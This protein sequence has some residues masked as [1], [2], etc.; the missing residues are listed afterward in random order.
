MGGNV[1]GLRIQICRYKIG[2]VKNSIGNGVTKELVC[3][4]HRLN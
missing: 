1:Q 2:H 4:T 3:V